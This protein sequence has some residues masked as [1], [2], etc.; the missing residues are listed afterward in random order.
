MHLHCW[1]GCQQPITKHAFSQRSC[2]SHALRRGQQHLVDGVVG[3][4]HSSKARHQF[5]TVK[6]SVHPRHTRQQRR[7][8][9]PLYQST[10]VGSLMPPTLHNG[11]VNISCLEKLTC[12]HLYC[13]VPWWLTAHAQQPNKALAVCNTCQHPCRKCGSCRDG[14]D[15]SHDAC[16]P[17]TR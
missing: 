11:D 12:Q 5:P 8:T 15:A 16:A 2:S 14:Q 6:H 1:L 17:H 3:R 9:G 7:D 10:P 4:L 13:W